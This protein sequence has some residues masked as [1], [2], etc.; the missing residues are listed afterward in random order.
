MASLIPSSGRI[1]ATSL[2]RSRGP[3]LRR[4][5]MTAARCAP[6]HRA[7]RYPERPTAT[8]NQCSDRRHSTAMVYNC[9]A[10]CAKAGVGGIVP[11]VSRRPSSHT[12][13]P[14]HWSSDRISRNASN[15]GWRRQSRKRHKTTSKRS[16][17]SSSSVGDPQQVVQLTATAQ[18]NALPPAGASHIC[19]IRNRQGQRL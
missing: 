4:S 15:G 3:S 2:S 16:R 7:C 17:S 11:M 9:G 14:P 13:S 19:P 18:V 1:P 10:T 12:S 8:L 5:G 6:A